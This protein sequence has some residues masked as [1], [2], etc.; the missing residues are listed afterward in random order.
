MN[1]EI[2]RRETI[3]ALVGTYQQ[4][5]EQV[6]TAYGL[7][8]AAKTNLSS[9]FLSDYFH[10][11]SGNHYGPMSDDLAKV[12]DGI[13]RRAWMV[14]VDRL[15]IR[16]ILSIKRREE[17]DRQLSGESRNSYEKVAELPEITEANILSMFQDGMAKAT[18]YANEAVYEVF[19]WLRPGTWQRTEYKTN[20]KWKLGRKVIKTWVVEPGYGRGLFRVRYGIEKNVTALD[21]VFHMLDGR[22]ALNTHNGP[23]TDAIMNSAD[24]YGETDFFK[25][26]CC[27]NGNIHLEFKRMDLVA[28]INKTAGGNRIGNAK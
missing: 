14:I 21:N 2:A 8:D 4:A 26:R 19:D 27:K 6:T 20:D 3:T 11:L 7:L 18:D 9:V 22:G 13:K 23:L 24:G 15:E 1:S 17:L 12:L 16:R 28:K 5:V 10:V 25:F